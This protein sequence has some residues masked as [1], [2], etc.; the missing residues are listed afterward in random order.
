MSSIRGMP[1][2]KPYSYHFCADKSGYLGI[3][4]RKGTAGSAFRLSA[5]FKL[6]GDGD[7]KSCPV[8]PEGLGWALHDFLSWIR[9]LRNSSPQPLPHLFDSDLRERQQVGA[10]AG[11]E[12]AI[13][14]V[15]GNSSQMRAKAT[16]PFRPRRPAG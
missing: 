5:R 10:F 4:R 1:S 16:D 9:S 11:H 14:D 13:P 8:R 12:A 6:H 3:K 15:A 7:D 2:L